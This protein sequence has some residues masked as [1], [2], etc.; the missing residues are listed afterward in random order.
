M[1]LKTQLFLAI[2]ARF[3]SRFEGRGYLLD[4]LDMFSDR[5]LF[6]L[7]FVQTSVDAVGQA[8]ELLFCRPSIFLNGPQQS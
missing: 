6:G 1:M 5:L 2:S 8:A 3:V 4:V 7:H